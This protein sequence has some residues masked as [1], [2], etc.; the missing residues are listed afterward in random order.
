MIIIFTLSLLFILFPKVTVWQGIYPVVV[1]HNICFVISGYLPL[2]PYTVIVWQL[3]IV[4]YLIISYLF[5]HC[6]LSCHFWI[7]FNIVF[8][9]VISYLFWHCTLPCHFW[10]C[11]SQF[12]CCTWY[13]PALSSLDIVLYLVIVGHAV[14][15]ENCENV[16]V[17]L[18]LRLDRER[19]ISWRKRNIMILIQKERLKRH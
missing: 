19:L 18:D 15:Y 1:G 16:M 8:Y 3:D 14:V 10:I 12:C 13:V 7:C 11:F 5:W 6:T 4:F 17:I 2:F 9:L